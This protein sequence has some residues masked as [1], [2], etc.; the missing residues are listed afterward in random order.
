[1]FAVQ[2]TAK[3]YFYA[4]TIFCTSAGNARC[5]IIIMYSTKSDSLARFLAFFLQFLQ[6]L[7]SNV[8]ID[9]KLHEIKHC[10]N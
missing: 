10:A 9:E 5:A 7:N 6:F 3:N 2:K 1:M 4:D 8:R